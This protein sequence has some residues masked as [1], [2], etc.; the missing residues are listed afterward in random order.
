MESNSVCDIYSVS[1]KNLYCRHVCSLRFW[2]CDTNP[3]HGFPILFPLTKWF[4]LRLPTYTVQRRLFFTTSTTT[5]TSITSLTIRS[6]LPPYWSRFEFTSM[7]S[8]NPSICNFWSENMMMVRSKFTPPQEWIDTTQSQSTPERKYKWVH[9]ITTRS[10]HSNHTHHT[11]CLNTWID[12]PIK[13]PHSQLGKSTTPIV[14]I[15]YF[16]NSY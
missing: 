9:I 2:V 15:T 5:G 11:W 14:N 13:I 8:L 4:T 1:T 10:R 12:T 6:P 16:R 7:T 3:W